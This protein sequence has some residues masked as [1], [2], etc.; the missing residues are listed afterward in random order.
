MAIFADWYK[1]YLPNRLNVMSSNLFHS[2]EYMEGENTG[3]GVTGTQG[4]SLVAILQGGDLCGKMYITKSGRS[5]GQKRTRSKMCRPWEFIFR[6]ILKERKWRGRK[7]I[8]L[9]CPNMYFG[10]TASDYDITGTRFYERQWKIV[11]FLVKK[12]GR[13]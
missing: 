2:Q 8:N 12:R 4:A 7:D 3:R 13:D 9:K 11:K 10:Y 6:G 1:A 5:T